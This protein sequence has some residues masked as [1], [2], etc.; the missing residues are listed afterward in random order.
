[1]KIETQKYDNITVIEL[2]GEFTA[3]FENQLYDRI[4]VVCND[5]TMGIVIDLSNVGFIDS[6]GLEQLLEIRDYCHKNNHQI[7]L[8]GLDELCMK[9]MEITR[10]LPKFDIYD[11]LSEAVKSFV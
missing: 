9:I 11:E 5:N 7:K 10:L 3:E 1:M 8:A 4:E 6:M 2:I